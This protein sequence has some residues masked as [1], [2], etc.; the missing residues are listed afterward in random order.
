MPRGKLVVDEVDLFLGQNYLVTVS[1]HDPTAPGPLH[2]IERVVKLDPN[3][4]RQGPAFLMH[5]ILDHIVDR[6]FA[7]IETLEDELD[8]AEE[9][10]MKDPAH[11][12]PAELL[13]LRRELLAIRKC[14]FH[15]RE[16]PS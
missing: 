14:L 10:M 9:T 16:L 13:L 7:A 6:K 4:A 8:A 2:D 11:F 1:G 3:G 15:E 5:M 12:D